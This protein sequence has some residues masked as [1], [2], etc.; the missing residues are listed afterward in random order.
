MD[1]QSLQDGNWK[2]H[3]AFK[4]YA[5]HL[6][7]P[8]WLTMEEEEEKLEKERRMQA[9][10]PGRLIKLDSDAEKIKSKVFKVR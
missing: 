7:S 5:D 4:A 3:P 8:R 9:F 6:D 1:L 2:E 10:S